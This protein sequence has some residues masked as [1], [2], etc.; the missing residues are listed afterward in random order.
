MAV[1]VVGPF[2][3]LLF[4]ADPM[5]PLVRSVHVPFG[6]EIVYREV[7]PGP[8]SLALAGLSP[9]GFV[10]LVIAVFRLHRSGSR[11]RA[12]SVFVAGG[13]FFVA[14]VNDALV[15]IGAYAFPYLIEYAFM[16]MVLLMAFTLTSEVVEAAVIRDA[17][18]ES[19]ARFQAIA[20]D[21]R[22]LIADLD[23]DGRYRFV[24]ASYAALTGRSLEDLIGTQAAGIVYEDDRE[25]IDRRHAEAVARNESYVAEWRTRRADGEIRWVATHSSPYRARDGRTHWLVVSRDVTDQRRNEI[26]LTELIDQ[27]EA[28]NAEM[29]RF[30]YTV[31]HEL[32]TPLVT[33]SGFVGLLQ[34]DLVERDEARVREDLDTLVQAVARMQR[35]LDELLELSRVGRIV[36]PTDDLDL[37]Q[38][39]GEAAEGLDYWMKERGVELVVAEDLPPVR[40]DR[41]RLLIAVRNLLENAVKFAGDA[42]SPRIELGGHEEGDDTVIF[43]RDNGI[44]IDPTRAEAVFGLFDQL[45]PSQEGTGVGLALVKRVIDAHGGEVWV[46][47]EGE[48]HGSTFWITLP[49]RTPGA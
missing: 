48:G 22:N 15:G 46:D 33:I 12:I 14:V 37:M 4:Q 31:S 39:V 28:R 23:E 9:V 6:G 49:R 10:Y 29:E 18:L 25:A 36:H 43:V 3:G 41:S 19:D 40:A 7:A 47:S 21:P 13:L 26:R 1:G 35:R 11:R 27:L 2:T 32:K 42:A 45:D 44:G 20:A 8:L 5:V 16:A 30:T 24:N 38:L 17:L 34:R